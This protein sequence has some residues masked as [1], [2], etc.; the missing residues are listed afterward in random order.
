MPLCDTNCLQT[1]GG[2]HVDLGRLAWEMQRRWLQK[3]PLQALAGLLHPVVGK[4]TL[5]FR[6]TEN[7]EIHSVK[8][9]IQKVITKSSPT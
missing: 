1:L 3:I 2:K 7:N 5:N 6:D 8:E 4:H 9:Q